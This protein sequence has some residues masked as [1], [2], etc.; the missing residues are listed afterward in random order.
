M[1][2]FDL[3]FTPEKEK[4]FDFFCSCVGVDTML[5]ASV[6]RFESDTPEMT[7]FIPAKNKKN[8]SGKVICQKCKRTDNIYKIV[9][10]DNPIYVRN[11]SSSGDTT[12]SQLYKGT[13]QEDCSEGQQD[14][15]ATEIKL[16]SNNKTR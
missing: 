4:S 16:N 13:Y 1:G 6:T 14:I 15:T 3:S 5:I 8:A 2:N 12:Y 7:F 10:G 9:Y 11:I